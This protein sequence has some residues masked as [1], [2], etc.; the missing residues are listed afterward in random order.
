M[1]S[2]N[3]AVFKEAYAVVAFDCRW[4]VLQVESAGYALVGEKVPV[5]FV[6]A[7]VDE[8]A[9]AALSVKVSHAPPTQGCKVTM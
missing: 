2:A 1:C 5:T 4:L 6:V 7:A 3:N 9:S 8:V